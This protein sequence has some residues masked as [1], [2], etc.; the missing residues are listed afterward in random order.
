MPPLVKTEP[1]QLH[2]ALFLVPLFLICELGGA[3][4]ACQITKQ[5]SASIFCQ[6]KYVRPCGKTFLQVLMFAIFAVFSAIHKN[7]FPQMKVTANIFPAQI[8]SRVN[9]L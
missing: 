9:I 4:P 3:A 6:R 7:K 8:Y 2:T 5:Y 1:N